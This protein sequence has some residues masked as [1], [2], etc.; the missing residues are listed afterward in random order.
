MQTNKTMVYDEIKDEL[1]VTYESG[2]IR[3]FFDRVSDLDNLPCRF[4]FVEYDILKIV[5]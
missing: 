2:E 3:R 1:T 4:K 5:L